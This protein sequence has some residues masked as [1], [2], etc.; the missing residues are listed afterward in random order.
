MNNIYRAF[1]FRSFSTRF[2][3]PLTAALVASGPSAR[4]SLD[5][6]GDEMGDLW[7]A[8]FSAGDL[9]G[10]GDAD[11]DG[12]SNADESRL[13]TNPFDAESYFGL[14][15]YDVDN[16]AELVNL[17][18]HTTPGNRY[19][20]QSS[21]HL[22]A[23]E[24]TVDKVVVG[25]SDGLVSVGCPFDSETDVRM[26][27]RIH[28]VTD[29]DGDGLCAWEE[30]LLGLDDN[31]TNSNGESA[32]GDLAWAVDQL[33]SSEPVELTDGTVLPPSPPSMME[34]SRF[35]NQATFGAS[36]EDIEAMAL[37][38]TSFGDWIDAQ[39]ALPATTMMQMIEEEN[40]FLTEQQ[41]NPDIPA[42]SQQPQGFI[43]NAFWR[44]ALTKD[45]QLRQRV[46]FALSEILV[47]S[48]KGADIVRNVPVAAATH[49][50]HLI[51]RSFGNSG[52]LFEDMTMNISM[53]IYLGH[54]RNRKAIPER[55]IF[56][57]ENYAREVMQLFSIGLWELNRDGSHRLDEA[58]NSI[59][60][61]TN[62]QI[63]ELAKVMTG[64]NWGGT[65]SFGHYL[66]APT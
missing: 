28:L 16:E 42:L 24:W 20:I 36:Y 55:G 65:N 18:F 66:W 12:V 3:V 61:Y 45:D 30:R 17:T 48:G 25:V 47:I 46:A 22:G 56:P 51:N 43:R 59:P 35:L 57:D 8:K 15:G 4:A 44:A 2:V 62:D 33:Y 6:D 10:Q 54:L 26:F 38:G 14:R 34:V 52:D 11:G 41:Y 49:H 19:E 21:N 7:Q 60:S 31:D 39:M 63:V 5:L 9:A 37:A 1:S 32:G 58:G 27:Y 53:G 13:S 23:D 29:A 64:F 50:N 40:A